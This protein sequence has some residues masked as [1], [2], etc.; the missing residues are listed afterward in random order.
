[1]CVEYE[2]SGVNKEFFVEGIVEVLILVVGFEL[3]CEI[4]F[5][6]IDR[7]VVDIVNVE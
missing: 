7:G 5:D 1:M 4:V 3:D 6:V 2:V